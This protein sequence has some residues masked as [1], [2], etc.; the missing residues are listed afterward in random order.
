M[1]PLPSLCRLIWHIN[2][3]T[4]AKLT[5][6][7]DSLPYLV[8]LEDN[9]FR[10]ILCAQTLHYLKP[11]EFEHAV[12]GLYKLLKVGGTLYVTVGSPYIKVYKG[13]GEEYE[14]RLADHDDFPGYMRDVK[15][16]IQLE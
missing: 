12:R 5:T 16:N 3:T 9:S 4:D 15:K 7:C 1:A 2:L 13:F 14:R 11:E 8:K 6:V 10:S